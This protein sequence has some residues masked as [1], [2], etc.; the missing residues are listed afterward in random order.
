LKT[1]HPSSPK[2]RPP[3]PQLVIEPARIM[4]GISGTRQLD[5]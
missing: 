1:Y 4:E 5:W 2:K 3:Y